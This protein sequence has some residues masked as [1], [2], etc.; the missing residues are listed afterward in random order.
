MVVMAPRGFGKAIAEKK[1][2]QV[3]TDGG[4]HNSL[5]QA[6]HYEFLNSGTADDGVVDIED[7]ELQAL[8]RR[9]GNRKKMLVRRL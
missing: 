7:M 6:P 4:S 1:L 8:V 5:L 3:K 9:G 2:G